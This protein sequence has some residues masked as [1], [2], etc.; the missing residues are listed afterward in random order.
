MHPDYRRCGVGTHLLEWAEEHAPGD[1][2]ELTIRNEALTVDAHAIY[3]SRG[4]EQQFVEDAMVRHLGIAVGEI[5]LPAD[6]ELVLPWSRKTA[7][8]FFAAYR[9]S[10]ADRPGFREPPGEEW[11]DDHDREEFRR[12]LSLIA[13]A[14]GEPVGFLTVELDPPAGWIDQMGVVPTWRRRGLGAALIAQT[15]RRFQAEGLAEA[16]LHVNTNN[17]GAAAL[18]E[19][20]GFRKQLQRARYV[21]SRH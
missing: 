4:F 12:D 19:R 21:K 17:P 8:L 18:Y 14:G 20:L 3:V 6:V 9:A 16:L 5:P 10:F 15:L 1:A 11:V 7:A 2:A 13:L